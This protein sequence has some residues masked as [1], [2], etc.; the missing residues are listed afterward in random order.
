MMKIRYGIRRYTVAKTISVVDSLKTACLVINDEC[1]SL[2]F[3]NKYRYQAEGSKR[4]N[5]RIKCM[6]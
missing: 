4:S 3:M 5:N 1:N 6:E 2:E